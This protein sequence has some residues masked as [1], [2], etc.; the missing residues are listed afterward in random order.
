MLDGDVHIHIDVVRRGNRPVELDAQVR[1]GRIQ[2]LDYVRRE[3]HIAVGHRSG[4]LVFEVKIYVVETPEIRTCSPM[5]ACRADVSFNWGASG[6]NPPLCAQ[7]ANAYSAIAASKPIM[8][9]D[10]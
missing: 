2:K 4:C 9:L 7:P 10:I 1:C 3:L 6:D 8:I 5:P